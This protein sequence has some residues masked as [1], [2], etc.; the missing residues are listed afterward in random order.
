MLKQQVRL[1][2][3][4]L[5]GGTTIQV[6]APPTIP[7]VVRVTSK[8]TTSTT[9]S[10]TTTTMSPP[11]HPNKSPRPNQHHP[12]T[13]PPP[14]VPPR[15]VVVHTVSPPLHKPVVS[16]HTIGRAKQ[17][18]INPTPLPTQDSTVSPSSR[19]DQEP[20]GHYPTKPQDTHS[21]KSPVHR[22]NVQSSKDPV[23]TTLAW[24]DPRVADPKVADPKVAD[25]KVADPGVAD[26]R[27]ADPKVVDPGVA[28]PKVADPKVADPR[29]ADLGV[30]KAP[31]YDDCGG[32]LNGGTCF[33]VQGGASG[34]R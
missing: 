16:V 3:F 6:P 29:V 14:V 32:C 15:T 13:N 26:P 21:N 10:T 1:C 19:L 25:P 11:H 22:N 12:M 9:T 34:C 27:V 31:L 30:A 20:H 8:K 7:A 28:D 24:I 18:P 2:V 17:H 4:L 23:K 5:P 33:Y